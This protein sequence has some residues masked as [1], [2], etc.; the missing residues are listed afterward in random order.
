MTKPFDSERSGVRFGESA[1][2]T[3]VVITFFTWAEN[4]F[5]GS[6]VS[7]EGRL[8]LGHPVRVTATKALGGASGSFLIT[9]KKPEAYSSF[10]YQSIWSD[11]EDVWVLIQWRCDGQLFDSML[12]MLDSIDSTIT[13]EAYGK[14]DETY[15]LHGRD[16][17]KVFEE[18]IQYL[19]PFLPGALIAYQQLVNVTADAVVNGTPANFVKALIEAWIGGGFI[20]QA[21][22]PPPGLGL[23]SRF[24]DMLDLSGIES[25]TTE[26]NG[27][28]TT[29]QLMNPDQ[30]G[31]T[32]WDAMQQY[33]NGI[34][35]ELYV[36]LA[37]PANNPYGRTG[38]K[39]TV[40]LRERKFPTKEGGSSD[41][42]A[43]RTW[44]LAP[45]LIH[46]R[47]VAK[48]GA[49]TRYNFWHLYPAGL[50][51]VDLR[52]YV[53]RGQGQ[54]GL[55]EA[56]PIWNEQSIRRHGLRR[57]ENTTLFIPNTIGEKTPD[58]AL[59]DTG[60]SS[61]SWLIELAKWL[62]KIHD[63]YSIAPK[64]LSGTINTTRLLPE[65]R[66]G[67]RIVEQTESGDIVYYCEGVEHS[68]QYPG[69]G[70]TRLTVTRGEYVASKLLDAE[71]APLDG[72]EIK[73][74]ALLEADQ[75]LLLENKVF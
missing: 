37:P 46:S 69:T 23:A 28:A 49:S 21:W 56:N 75:K 24:F 59:E 4:G 30:D 38:L 45:H 6:T 33:C 2:N 68:W 55:A 19:N 73:A 67:S 13:R 27:G 25:M 35:N 34:L 63:W 36:D 72:Q 70:Q 5:S 41:Y 8:K 61:D 22:Q 9:M 7:K 60:V 29:F 43:L 47:Q 62:L 66:I 58:R 48:G 51:S 15:E 57:W 50:G 3:E 31:S 71:Y 64:Q 18:T 39:P 10:D 12:G 20:G 32:V 42:E 53:N 16:F 40:F 26:V 14:R 44:E 74:R 11:P 17:G 65:I 54:P 1:T 52:A